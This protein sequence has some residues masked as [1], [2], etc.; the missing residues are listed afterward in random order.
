LQLRRRLRLD[1][2]LAGRLF[3]R[4]FAGAHAFGYLFCAREGV[5]EVPRSL[6]G[7]L[8]AAL[9]ATISLDAVPARFSHVSLSS[10]VI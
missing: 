10:A 6:I 4:L 5:E 1:A 2:P 8:S 7:V 9:A 3:S